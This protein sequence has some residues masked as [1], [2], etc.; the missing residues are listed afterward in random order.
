SGRATA[1]SRTRPDRAASAAAARRTGTRSGRAPPR[2]SRRQLHGLG[3]G[4]GQG[5]AGTAVAHRCAATK[6]STPGSFRQRP[7]GRGTMNRV[8]RITALSA[9][10][11][12]PP[13]PVPAQNLTADTLTASVVVAT[14]KWRVP[15]Y[16][17]APGHERMS[18]PETEAFVRE[19]RRLPDIPGAAEIGEKGMDVAE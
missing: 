4:A 12:A 14:P 18:L 6:N 10:L 15:D 13:A 11:F 19:H 1:A 7:Q 3:A 2:A 9:G 16:V 17:F 8:V 5:G